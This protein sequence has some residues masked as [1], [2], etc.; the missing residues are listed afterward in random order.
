[1]NVRRDIKLRPQIYDSGG[2]AEGR[3]R[4]RTSGLARLS[5]STRA[6]SFRLGTSS[7]LRGRTASDRHRIVSASADIP[8]VS[9][10]LIVSDDGPGL[11]PTPFVCSWAM[12]DVHAAW[13][14]LSGEL[15]LAAAPALK[16][17]LREAQNQAQVVVLDLRDLTFMD[18]SGIHAILPGSLF[19]RRPGHRLI[20]VRGPKQI[21]RLLDLAGVRDKLDIADSAHEPPARLGHG[22]PTPWV[23]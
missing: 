11:L 9:P 22:P 17:A 5:S 1:M 12:N 20:L 4:W 3:R 18:S 23:A 14:H 21:D 15:D 16:D 6:A 8:T 19:A 2:K 10:K 13:V 7:T